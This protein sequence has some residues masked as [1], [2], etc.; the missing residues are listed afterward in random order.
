MLFSD[1]VRSEVQC[2]G[3]SESAE[4][5]DSSVH[6]VVR[7]IAAHSS[8][9]AAEAELCIAASSPGIAGGSERASIASATA[10]RRKRGP[11]LSRRTG[12]RG[13]VF[14]KGPSNAVWNPAAPAYG[15][16]W[17]DVPG[18]DRQRKVIALGVCP[19][20]SVAKRKLR[21]YIESS[22]VN[23]AQTFIA[24]T[25]PATTFRSQANAWI[26]ALSKRRRR[27][28]KPA[29]LQSWRS[30]LDKWLLPNLGDMPL[31]DVA[32]GAMK[33]LVDK[34]SAA[35]LSAKSIVN[36]CEVVKLVVASAVNAEGEEIYP[37]KWNHEFVGI[38]IVDKNKQRRPTLTAEEVLAIVSGVKGQ[39]RTSLRPPSWNWPPHRGSPRSKNNQPCS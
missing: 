39:Y 26:E 13:N 17:I 20:A 8:E 19:T 35:G 14:Q 12:Q 27:P 31:A 7:Q 9:A 23:N 33:T 29:T 1:D 28:V 34:M 3:P 4:Q 15:R 6:P 30:C 25:A 10:I 21:E 22:G 18:Q 24:A 38:P 36:Y 2:A 32:N 16:F 37:R 5:R 11:S